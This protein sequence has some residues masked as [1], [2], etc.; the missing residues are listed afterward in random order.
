MSPIYEY[1]CTFCDTLF[2]QLRRAEDHKKFGECPSCGRPG[3]RVLSSFSFDM[4][5]NKGKKLRRKLDSKQ[6]IG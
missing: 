5:P 1:R 3:K 4:S 6:G 2:S